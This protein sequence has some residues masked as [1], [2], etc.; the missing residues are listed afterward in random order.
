[1][2][3]PAGAGTPVPVLVGTTRAPEPAGL[4][5]RDARGALNFAEIEVSVPAAHEPGKVELPRGRV[6]DPARDFVTRAVRPAADAAAFRAALQARIPRSGPNAG[7]VIVTVHGFNN[8]MGDGLYRTV[9]MVHDL[10]MESPAVHYAWPS[11]G[12]PLG[13]A[14]DRDS[15]LFARDGLERLL[16][17]VGRAGARR[18]VVVAHSMGAQLAMETLRQMALRGN[19]RTLDRIGGVV[20]MAPDIDV[21]VF[22]AQAGAVGRMSQPIVIF[23][24][25]RDPALA[26]SARLTGR[27]SRLGNIDGVE[28][29]AGLDV[30]VIDLTEARD[31]E[32]RHYAALT[33]PS[34]MRFLERTREVRNAMQADRSG[35]TGI[36]P[37]TMLIA[38]EATAVLLAPI[39]LVGEARR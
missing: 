25:R 26:L 16:D 39:G 35:R 4:W 21:G 8:T 10:D 20:L 29:L 14:A 7:E 17:E 36:V 27:P 23:T 5:T 24:S 6:P 38:Q 37:G 28:A 34:V 19:R 9:Q 32:E 12:R 18:I 33:S 13:Y 1:M 22:R 11:A 31:A 2:P 30:T 3:V 15:A